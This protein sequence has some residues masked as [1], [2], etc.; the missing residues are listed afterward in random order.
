MRPAHVLGVGLVLLAV[1]SLCAQMRWAHDIKQTAAG[2]STT[3]LRQ[4]SGPAADPNTIVAPSTATA[5]PTE[6]VFNRAVFNQTAFRHGFTSRFPN[7]TRGIVMCLHD[8]MAALGISLIQEL[9]LLNN[10]LPI[11]VYTCLDEELSNAT[12]S[13]VLEVDTLN[14]T[15]IV[16]VCRSVLDAKYMLQWEAVEYQNFFLKIL[17]V[18][19]TTFDEVLLLD[20]DD[21]FLANP[22]VLWTIDSYVETGTLFFY[23]RQINFEQFFNTVLL[24]DHTL[25]NRLFDSF[26]Y[27]KFGLQQPPVTDQLRASRAWQHQTA[28]EQDSSVVLLHKSR[29]GLPMLQ[30]LWYL[31]DTVRY[32][33]TYTGDKEYFWLSCLLSNVSYAFSPHPAAVV[34]RLDDMAK[35]PDTLCGSLTHYLPVKSPN[36]PLLHVNGKDI[37]WPYYDSNTTFWANATWAEKEAYLVS[38]I[39]KHVTP[40]QANRSFEADRDKLDQT[41]LVHQG[42]VPIAAPY[43][44]SFVARRIH[45]TIAAAQVV[46]TKPPPVMFDPEA[47]ISFDA[48]DAAKFENY[49]DS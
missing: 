24:W 49:R 39:P 13:L 26:P 18:L 36:P 5:R 23:D 19:H 4:Q 28:H 30:V 46:V 35:H 38:A 9:R 22:D 2:V 17:A 31:V 45:H 42:A 41:C 27:D 47:I 14:R 15:E 21:I 25:L 16:D 1:A 11:Q 44:A 34:S 37:L 33:Q 43:F 6:P 12:R 10:S 48:V 3:L 20:A 32:E 8:N 40:L 29:L 7:D